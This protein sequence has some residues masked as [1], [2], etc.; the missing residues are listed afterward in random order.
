MENRSAGERTKFAEKEWAYY[1]F[2]GP[3]FWSFRLDEQGRW[4]FIT[5]EFIYGGQEHVGTV[6][7]RVE[8]LRKA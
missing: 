5:E 3:R 8:V 2:L 7:D 4:E 6:D 1:C